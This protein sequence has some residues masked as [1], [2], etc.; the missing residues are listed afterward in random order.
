MFLRSAKKE[1]TMNQAEFIK[2]FHA[3]LAESPPETAQIWCEFA[4]ESVKRRHAHFR[5]DEKWNA[6]SVADRLDA[7]YDGLCQTREA[8][9]SELS[10]KDCS[11]RSAGS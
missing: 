11:I 7:L 4:S 6:S 1:E 2:K 3:F 10:T 9:S 5:A 8:Y